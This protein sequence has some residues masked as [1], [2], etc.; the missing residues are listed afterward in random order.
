[1]TPSGY[2]H[3]TYDVVTPEH[4][5]MSMPISEEIYQPHGFCTAAPRAPCWNRA[6]V[7]AP[8]RTDF[9]KEPPFGLSPISATSRANPGVLHSF[10]DLELR[11]SQLR[12]SQAVGHVVAKRRRRRCGFRRHLHHQD[13]HERAFRR[14]EPPARTA[15]TR[16][17][18]PTSSKCPSGRAV[19]SDTLVTVWGRS[20]KCPVCLGHA[21]VLCVCTLPRFGWFDLFGR[22]LPYFEDAVFV[23]LG[24]AWRCV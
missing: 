2:L 10:A 11:G 17:D 22:F 12:R 15:L 13:R 21:A 5:E 20:T 6:Q 4:V 14:K 19:A 24:F 16:T 1:M 9:D 8:R 7:A 3:I 23:V 18:N